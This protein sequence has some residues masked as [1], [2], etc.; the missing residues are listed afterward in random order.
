MS[1]HRWL[2]RGSAPNFKTATTSSSVKLSA[3]GPGVSIADLNHASDA[4]SLI[5]E[6]KKLRSKTVPPAVKVSVVKHL[7]LYGMNSALRTFRTRYPELNFSETSVRR[8]KKAQSH[9]S[10]QGIELI[11]AFPDL[12]GRPNFLSGELVSK[13][14]QIIVGSRAAGIGICMN[15]VIAIGNSVTSVNCPNLLE[16]NG[17]SVRLTVDWARSILKNL[18]Y[19]L[20]KA[21]TEKRKPSPEF[22]KETKLQFQ[23]A[24]YKEVST[25]KIPSSLI[26]NTDQTPLPYVNSGNATYE[27]R[28]ENVVPLIGKGDKRKITATFTV[29]ADGTFLPMQL[30]Y[31]G[32]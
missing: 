6:R 1:L 2:T 8:W 9:A 23:H 26:L 27:Q 4:V 29:S 21:T 32:I 30:I 19:T 14:N 16:E 20:K 31:S 12:R 7:D 3:I 24:I 18:N 28:G 13:V 22:L 11:K 15:D 17:G 10:S 25:Y 5:S